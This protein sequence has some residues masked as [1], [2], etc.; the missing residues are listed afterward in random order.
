MGLGIIINSNK[1][2]GLI[3]SQAGRVEVY[4]RLGKT[5]WYSI[6]LSEDILDGNFPK[7][8]D[9]ELDPGTEVAIYSSIEE[10]MHCLVKGPI[11]SQQIHFEHGGQGSWVEVRGG[12][13][14][15]EMDREFKFQQW[16]NVTDGE[17]VMFL[18]RKYGLDPNIQST[19]TRHLE[20][21]HTLIQKETDLRFIRRLARRNGCYFWISYDKT[22]KEKANFQRPKLNGSTAEQL[23]INFE[24][25]NIDTFELSWDVE[26]PTSVEGVQLNLNTKKEI[27]GAVDGTPQDILGT[28][29]LKD[30]TK[31]K[32]S[33]HITS[34]S[35]DAGNLKARSE[36]ALI[37]SDWF[38]RANCT[39]SLHRLGG[40]IRSHT[41][42]NVSGIG[43]RHSG[44]YF[45][46]GVRH[47][48]DQTAHKMEVELVR[49]GW[50]DKGSK[51]DLLATVSNIF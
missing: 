31:D 35:D 42:V 38:I 44:N 19:K 12:D 25:N 33:T 1:G 17:A 23:I 21:K 11:T 51:G 24:N 3:L 37:E 10:E 40:L 46:V 16:S 47:I 7:L 28:K 39:T 36:S 27:K 13:K 43:S 32:R 50:N 29:K 6:Q 14:S 4:E 5:T 34:P 9:V 49:N 26:R 22:G 30:I 15:I 20:T 18:V 48:I 2:S 41:L 45:V 8:E